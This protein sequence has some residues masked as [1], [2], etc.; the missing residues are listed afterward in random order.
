V[1]SKG[2]KKMWGENNTVKWSRLVLAMVPADPAMVGVGTKPKV[3]VSVLIRQRPRLSDWP[4][5]ATWTTL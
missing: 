1:D 3:L 4:H 2:A 5:L